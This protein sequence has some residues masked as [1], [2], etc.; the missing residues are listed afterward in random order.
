M[1]MAPKLS[2][3]SLLCAFTSILPLRP[4]QGSADQLSLKYILYQKL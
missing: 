1:E 3:G 4:S 2:W